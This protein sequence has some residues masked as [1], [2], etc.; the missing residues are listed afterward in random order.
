MP[1]P[2]YS[3]KPAVPALGKLWTVSNVLSV[4]RAFLA[5]P[6]A[7][8][9]ILDGP[10][11]WTLGLCVVAVATDWFDGVVARWSK[12]VSDWGKVLAPLADKVGATLVVTSLVIRGVLPWWLLALLFFRDVCI[13]MGGIMLAR[14]TNYVWMSTWPG[15]VAISVIALTVVGGLLRADPPVMQFL[16]WA[17]AGMIV[18]TYVLYLGRFI[19]EMVKASRARKR[20]RTAPEV[21]PEHPH[22]EPSPL[23]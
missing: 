22:T 9:I 18:L 1:S 5:I 6:I 8:L 16:I 20:L 13:V 19:T 4:S 23:D 3:Q 14:H 17:S 10:L 15:K 11:N 7:Y 21:A 2:D 12:T